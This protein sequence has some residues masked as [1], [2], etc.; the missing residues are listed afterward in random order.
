MTFLCRELVFRSRNVRQLIVERLA[1]S[2]ASPQE[3][4][5]VGNI[6]NR[7]GRF[8]EQ[9]PQFWMVPT[10]LMA[11]AIPVSADARA[12]P[13]HFC[14]ERVSIQTRK[15][16]IHTHRHSATISVGL[17]AGL[18]YEQLRPLS[19]RITASETTAEGRAVERRYFYR[20]A[21]EPSLEE[22]VKTTSCVRV[23]MEYWMNP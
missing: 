18:V 13:F 6:G 23:A 22:K 20:A 15:V 10:E 1:I 9:S 4:R 3:L 17:V 5:P 19:C 14:D 11:C 8:R 7:I 21:K 16:F 2:E 12:Q